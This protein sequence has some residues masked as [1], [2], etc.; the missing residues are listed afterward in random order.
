MGYTLREI[1][2]ARRDMQQEREEVMRRV[3]AQI[4]GAVDLSPE[5]MVDAAF[6]MVRKINEKMKDNG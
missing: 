1:I 5:E 6:V 4:H 3:I 2:A